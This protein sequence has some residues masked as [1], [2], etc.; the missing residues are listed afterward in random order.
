MKTAAAGT[1]CM[2]VAKIAAD[3]ERSVALN[4]N[5]AQP[6][7]GGARRGKMTP[8]IKNNYGTTYHRDK[9]VSFWNIYTQQWERDTAYNITCR[10][11]VYASLNDAERRKISKM[12]LGC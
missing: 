12:A 7:F 9:T 4:N 10:H 8:T 11:K 1:C 3:T 6:R 2:S 5:N